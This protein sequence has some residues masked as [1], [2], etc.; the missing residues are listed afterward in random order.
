MRNS[1]PVRVLGLVG[2]LSLMG[3]APAFAQQEPQSFLVERLY[4]SAPGGGWFAMD[5]LDIHGGLGGAIRSTISYA[6]APLRVSDGVNRVPVISNEAFLNI[7]AALTYQRWRFYLDL[8]APF[9]ID[10]E[11]GIVGSY[12]FH[13]PSLTLGSNPDTLADARIGTDV[14][15][16][17]APGG[18]FRLGAGAQLFVPCGDPTDYDSD[19]T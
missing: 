8:D 5:D 13:A 2:V 16:V 6:H 7:G 19:R 17:G 9:S 18:Y 11:S 4:L 14:R 10:G 3:V 15:L 1:S 12:S